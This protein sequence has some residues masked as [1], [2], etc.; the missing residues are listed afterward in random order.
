MCFSRPTILH[1]IYV[2]SDSVQ[3]AKYGF[4]CSRPLSFWLELDEE[5][6]RELLDSALK[7]LHGRGFIQLYVVS[8]CMDSDESTLADA[9]EELGELDGKLFAGGVA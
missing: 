3:I 9:L 2:E 8:A 4:I 5:D 7:R 1:A 6:E